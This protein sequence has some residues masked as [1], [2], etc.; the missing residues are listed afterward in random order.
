MCIDSFTRGFVDVV[1]SVYGCCKN[2]IDMYSSSAIQEFHIYLSVHKDAK[3]FTGFHFFV[4][5][6]TGDRFLCLTDIYYFTLL[7]LHFLDHL[8]ELKKYMKRRLLLAYNSSYV[9]LDLSP[10]VEINIQVYD[11]NNGGGINSLIYRLNIS[12]WRASYACRHTKL[13]IKENNVLY[14]N[15]WKDVFTGVIELAEV[16]IVDHVATYSES[17]NKIMFKNFKFTPFQTSLDNHSM[18][19]N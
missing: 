8:Q 17:G 5:H 15:K 7:H 3:Y 19:I 9:N 13:E 14:N 18:N 4:T 10:M 2:V 16:L 1:L 11:N 6:N 12:G